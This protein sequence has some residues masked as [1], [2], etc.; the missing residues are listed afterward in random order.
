MNECPQPAMPGWELARETHY[1]QCRADHLNTTDLRQSQWPRQ[2]SHRVLSCHLGN[3]AD[4]PQQTTVLSGGISPGVQAPQPAGGVVRSAQISLAFVEVVI[5]RGLIDYEYF[6]LAPNLL[7]CDQPF[8]WCW[9]SC[10]YTKERSLQI[11][12]S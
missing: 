2:D 8:G 5:M 4:L 1:A 7:N 10:T 6:W 9:P 12:V 3:P 11:A